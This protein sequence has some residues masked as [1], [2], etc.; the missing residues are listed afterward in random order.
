MID[1]SKFAEN[2]SACMDEKQ[3]NAP[4][5][6]LQIGTD[7]S[8]ITRY[9]QGKRLPSFEVFISL[10]QFFNISADVLLGRKD[11]TEQTGFMPVLPFGERLR[12]VMLETKTTQYRIEKE[13]DISGASMHAWLNGTTLP[14]IENLDKLADYMDVSIDY[15]LGRIRY[16]FRP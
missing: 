1:L 4:A 2:I 8:N 5:L 15:L 16:L 10:L 12:A 13:Q 6:A 11:Y 9:K 7:R 3:I 14:S